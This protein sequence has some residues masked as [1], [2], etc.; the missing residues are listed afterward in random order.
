MRRRQPPTAWRDSCVSLSSDEEE[1]DAVVADGQ[2]VWDHAFCV[3]CNCLIESDQASGPDEADRAVEEHDEVWEAAAL[4]SLR[5]HRLRKHKAHTPR[6]SPATAPL[7]CSEACR[8]LDQQ[9]SE[10]LREFLHY[11]SRTP[12]RAAKAAS[13]APTTSPP[14]SPDLLDAHTHTSP[15]LA[16]SLSR[17]EYHTRRQAYDDTDDDAPLSALPG[18]LQAAA[19]RSLDTPSNLTRSRV[20]MIHAT[21]RRRPCT[22]TSSPPKSVVLDSAP[23]TPPP[24]LSRSVHA[25]SPLDLMTPGRPHPVPPTSATHAP[26][27]LPATTHVPAS[28]SRPT[29]R[30]SIKAPATVATATVHAATAHAP[31]S[32]SG[33][34]GGHDP[35]PLRRATYH[36]RRAQPPLL[37]PTRSR[38]HP[39]DAARRPSPARSKRASSGSRSPYASTSLPSTSPRRP[40]LGWS[41]LPP[42]RDDDEPR[43]R[44]W[45]QDVAAKGTPM[46][47]ILQ[48]PH[49]D[50]IH[51][52][53]S[54]YWPA[55][56]QA[57]S[58]PS[59]SLPRGRHRKSLFHFAT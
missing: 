8:Q 5:R 30:L 38:A 41:A 36:D 18:P 39:M 35:A 11:V 19:S 2:G 28:S 47:P 6:V 12:S 49:D 31:S 14:S 33:G 44:T 48:L 42:P 13:L 59:G 32:L 57:P 29:Q 15:S 23:P 34:G 50:V 45:S 24:R 46:Y 55:P 1:E 53:Y 40:G 22:E 20:A 58:L 56:P 27:S 7:F 52:K 16:T 54:Q 25:A 21:P 51:D 17:A 37:A 3:V 4:S 43:T 9:R 10:G 26:V